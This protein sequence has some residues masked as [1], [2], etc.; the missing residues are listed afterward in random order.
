MAAISIYPFFISLA[1]GFLLAI[2][3]RLIWSARNRRRALT[4][5]GWIDQGLSGTGHVTGIRALG[6]SRFYISAQLGGSTFE[7]AAFVLQ[8]APRHDLVEWLLFRLHAKQELLI[9][10]ADLEPPPEFDFEMCNERWHGRTRRA[11]HPQ[12]GSWEFEETTPCIFTTQR[13]WRH[14]LAVALSA[15]F[16]NRHQELVSVKFQRRSPH[17]SASLPLDSLPVTAARRP[18]FFDTLRELASEAS[19]SRS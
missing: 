16:A 1:L 3:W 14:E 19:A 8:L 17:F 9:F 11:L 13:H 18:S 15:V 2:G 4:A 10:R 5:L 7:C 6:P 12:T